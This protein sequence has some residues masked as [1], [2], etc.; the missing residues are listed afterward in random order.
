[1]P[2]VSVIVPNYNHARFLKKRL[3]SILSQDFKDFE[4]IILDDCSNDESREIIE[5]YRTENRVREIIYND[6]NSGTTFKQWNKGIE[7]AKGEYIWIAESDDWCEPTFLSKTLNAMESIPSIGIVY[8][9]SVEHDEIE[10]NI[11]L[12]FNNNNRFKESFLTSYFNNG[13]REIIEKLVYENTIPNASAVLFKKNLYLLS[14]G[15]DENMRLAGDWMVWTKMLLMSDIY[16]IAEPL[17][18]F[19]LTASSVR[20][21]VKSVQ[22]LIENVAILKVIEQNLDLELI[23][24]LQIH[25]IRRI[26]NSFSFFEIRSVFNVL[27]SERVGLKNWLIKVA[28]A[29][30]L[31]IKFRLR[32]FF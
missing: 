17:N 12:S 3:E 16:F 7:L 9:Q 15:A 1:M 18:H 32:I 24:R 30:V 28:I 14:G 26:F 10:N 23:K 29:W 8:S 11:H 22:M 21:K 19:R 5:S 27:K 4:L 2:K 6:I 31:S 20:N 13:K 25:C